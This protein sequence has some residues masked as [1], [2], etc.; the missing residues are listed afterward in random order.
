M[1][2]E[3]DSIAVAGPAIVVLGYQL[4]ILDLADLVVALVVAMMFIVLRGASRRARRAR[5]DAAERALAEELAQGLA[6]RRLLVGAS[7]ED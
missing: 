6:E 3:V 7:R 2:T 4:G 5:I 1:F